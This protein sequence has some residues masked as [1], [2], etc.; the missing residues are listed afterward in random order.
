M[1]AV[2]LVADVLDRRAD[3]RLQAVDDALGEGFVLF[4]GGARLGG[5]DFAGQHDA[6]GGDQRLARH[7]RLGILGQE[8]VHDRVGD[9][10]RNLVRVAL[11]NAFRGEE[12]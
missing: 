9:A 12:E 2:L 8:G 10:V 5:A 7:T 1:E 4:L 11:G 3:Q 6:L